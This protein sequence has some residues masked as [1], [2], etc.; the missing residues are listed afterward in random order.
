MPV[1]PE[2]RS[3]HNLCNAKKK[4]GERCRAYAGQGTDHPGSGYCKFHFGNTKNQKIHAA[5]LEA[6]KRMVAFGAPIQIHPNEALLAMLYLS[7]GHVAWLRQE[8]ADLDVENTNGRPRP[9]NTDVIIRLYADERD[10]VARIA[11][12]AIDCGIAERQVAMMERFGGGIATVLRRV[13]EDERLALTKKQRSQLPDLL[14]RHLSDLESSP[15]E[16]IELKPLD[17][18][19]LD[20]D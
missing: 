12:A 17:V 1:T 5:R 6:K 14:R 7:S 10:R 15:D 13:F 3:M 19:P 9:F 4:N 18:D 8:L 16:M 20:L 2:Q 11:K